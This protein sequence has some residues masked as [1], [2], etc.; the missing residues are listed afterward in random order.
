MGKKHQ[1][2]EQKGKVYVE[3]LGVA[4]HCRV[5]ISRVRIGDISMPELG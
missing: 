2:A 1:G 4:E 5:E 3:F